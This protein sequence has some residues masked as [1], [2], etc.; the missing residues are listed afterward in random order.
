MA[1]SLLC[2]FQN[3]TEQRF[4][5]DCIESMKAEKFLSAVQ[6]SETNQSTL[7]TVTVELI[8]EP[9][10]L[11]NLLKDVCASRNSVVICNLIVIQPASTN[12]PII[13]DLDVAEFVRS[14][15]SSNGTDSV[16]NLSH[17]ET[18]RSAPQDPDH[19]DLS[20][21][22]CSLR[23]GWLEGHVVICSTDGTVLLDGATRVF[24]LNAMLSCGVSVTSQL[25]VVRC[26]QETPAWIINAIIL[27]LSQ[28]GD[29][30]T[31]SP[32][33]TLN[34]ASYQIDSLRNCQPG[35]QE[36]AIR[37]LRK[38]KVFN[39]LDQFIDLAL[40]VRSRELCSTLARNLVMKR[41][42]VLFYNN[43]NTKT[44]VEYCKR[45]V[46]GSIF[47]KKPRQDLMTE[48]VSNLQSKSVP[49]VLHNLFKGCEHDSILYGIRVE[50]P[51]ALGSV[52][53][54]ILTWNSE[55]MRHESKSH[56][57][58]AVSQYNRF[59]FRDCNQNIVIASKT[60]PSLVPELGC[61][62]GTGAWLCD[63]K[64]RTV[65]VTALSRGSVEQESVTLEVCENPTGNNL[66]TK[67]SG[68]DHDASRIGVKRKTPSF[69]NPQSGRFQKPYLVSVL[70]HEL[71]L[72]LSSLEYNIQ[73]LWHF[74]TTDGSDVKSFELKM[75]ARLK[76][77]C[78]YHADLYGDPRFNDI[79]SRLI[80]DAKSIR[81]GFKPTF[82]QKLLLH[83]HLIRFGWFLTPVLWNCAELLFLLTTV[84]DPRLLFVQIVQKDANLQ[85]EKTQN[86]GMASCSK[87]LSSILFE[88]LQEF[89][90]LSTEHQCGDAVVLDSNGSYLQHFQAVRTTNCFK[91]MVPHKVVTVS[92]A[93]A[94]LSCN[95]H[96]T[97]I[98]QNLYAQNVAYPSNE[99]E[100][101][102]RIIE[103]TEGRWCFKHLLAQGVDCWLMRAQADALV[104]ETPN[105]GH[106]SQWEAWR[107]F[108]GISEHDIVEISITE[109][110]VSNHV[111]A[112]DYGSGGGYVRI[113]KSP[114][115]SVLL[116]QRMHSDGNP[117]YDPLEFKANGT[118]VLTQP[119]IFSNDDLSASE[120]R[121][122]N[123]A[124]RGT[125]HLP[126]PGT[127]YDPFS[128][129]IPDS[130]PSVVEKPCSP[131]S[132]VFN[133]PLGAL[134]CLMFGTR[135]GFSDCNVEIPIGACILFSFLFPHRGALYDYLNR[136]FHLYI[137][138][139]DFSRIPG[140]NV[141]QRFRILA[142]SKQRHYAHG[143]VDF[144]DLSLLHNL[145]TYEIPGSV[146]SPF[147]L[148]R[149][150][151]VFGNNWVY[152]GD[153]N[154]AKEPNGYGTM[155]FCDC[156]D[157]RSGFFQNGHFAK[158]CDEHDDAVAATRLVNILY[159]SLEF[160][161]GG[162]N[163]MLVA[164]SDIDVMKEFDSAVNALMQTPNVLDYVSTAILNIAAA[165][166]TLPSQRLSLFKCNAKRVLT[167]FMQMQRSDELSALNHLAQLD[168][169]EKD[170]DTPKTESSSS[171]FPLA[172]DQQR[173]PGIINYGV[174]TE[175]SVSALAP[176]SD[177]GP[178]GALNNND[179][180]VPA[181][182]SLS[183]IHPT[184]FGLPN[185]GSTCYMNAS[186]Q[187]L[188]H[189]TELSHLFLD[190]GFDGSSL[191][192]NIDDPSVVTENAEVA[193]SFKKFVNYS[194]TDD[195]TSMV[196]D[197]NSLIKKGFAN[198]DKEHVG[199]TADSTECLFYLIERICPSMFRPT[200][201]SV[202]TC[203]NC[204]TRS[205]TL[206]REFVMMPFPAIR[207]SAAATFADCL[208]L[209]L[210]PEVM[211]TP[212]QPYCS[213]CSA[214]HDSQKQLFIKELPDVV[215]IILKRCV[216]GGSAVSTANR[217]NRLMAV[218]VE[219]DFGTHYEHDRPDVFRLYAAVCHIP[220]GVGHYTAYCQPKHGVSW[221]YCDDGSVT[222]CSEEVML[223]NIKKNGYCF[224]F[225]RGTSSDPPAENTAVFDDSAV[226]NSNSNPQTVFLRKALTDVQGIFLVVRNCL[227][228]EDGNSLL[229]QLNS[230]YS[231]V[232]KTVDCD[233]LFK[234]MAEVCTQLLLMADTHF[235]KTNARYAF[236]KGCE[237]LASHC[238]TSDQRYIL[239]K[240]QQQQP[241]PPAPVVSKLPLL[242]IP[243]FHSLQPSSLA[244]VQK[245]AS[246]ARVA[247][248]FPYSFSSFKFDLSF[249]QDVNPQI[250]SFL[251][252]E[253]TRVSDKYAYVQY[254][255]DYYTS[256]KNRHLC[257]INRPAP[258]I[259]K[260]IFVGLDT[261]DWFF[262]SLATLFPDVM[263][264]SP[265]L[266]NWDH[267]FSE[268]RVDC[269]WYDSFLRNVKDRRPQFVMHPVNLPQHLDQ[270][271]H[272][273]EN[274]DSHFVVSCIVFDWSQ[275][276]VSSKISVLDPYS[277]DTFI[278][279]V[280]NLYRKGKYFTS[281]NPVF[282]KA[283]I[284]PIQL[285]PDNI[286]CGVYI[287]ALAL[288]AVFGTLS[289]M[290][291]RLN[292]KPD[293]NDTCDV[294]LLLRTCVAWD[295]TQFPSLL[296][297]C[298]LMS[299]KFSPISRRSEAV[300][301]SAWWIQTPYHNIA[302]SLAI[303]YGNI[304]IPVYCSRKGFLEQDRINVFARN[305]TGKISADGPFFFMNDKLL[306]KVN[307]VGL[308]GH[309]L[310]SDHT[311][312]KRA[313]SAFQEACASPYV[314]NKK[315]WFC[316]SFGL[317]CVGLVC[318]CAFV[319]I[320][321]TIG[322]Q[323]SDDCDVGR[324]FHD[325]S[326]LELQLPLQTPSPSGPLRVVHGDPHRG[327][328]VLVAPEVQLIDFDRTYLIIGDCPPLFFF[329]WYATSI[330]EQR[331]NI[332]HI[333]AL[334]RIIKRSG[335]GA[336]H[337]YFSAFYQ[338]DNFLQ[339]KFNAD[340]F[341]LSPKTP[342]A[343]DAFIHLFQL[344]FE[345]SLEP[346][347]I[348][349]SKIQCNLSNDITIHAFDVPDPGNITVSC[350]DEPSQI[351]LLSSESAT[352]TFFEKYSKVTIS[353]KQ[354]SLAPISP[355]HCSKEEP[356]VSCVG[357][358]HLMELL[359]LEQDRTPQLLILHDKSFI[360]CDI[361]PVCSRDTFVPCKIFF[362]RTATGSIKI[363]SAEFDHP[364]CS[365]LEGNFRQCENV[366]PLNLENNE[367]AERVFNFALSM[368][369]QYSICS[370]DSDSDVD[371]SAEVVDPFTVASLR[372]G[373][374]V[375]Q[376][377][378]AASVNPALPEYRFLFQKMKN[379]GNLNVLESIQKSM[380]RRF[381][382]AGSLQSLKI[383]HVT[384]K[385]KSLNVLREEHFGCEI[386]LVEDDS[387]RCRCINFIQ[388][389]KFLSLDT[390]SAVPRHDEEGISLIQIGTSTNVFLIQVALQS[391]SFF[392]SLAD[393]LRN[394]TL[395]CWG[396]DEK[397][398]QSVVGNCNCTFEDVQLS[399]SSRAQKKGLD[400]CIEDLFKRKYVLNKN[401]RLSG[402]D[403]NPLSKGQLRYAAL[404]VVCCHAL[405]IANKVGPDFVYDS[406]GDHVTFYAHDIVSG[407][408]VKHG[409]SFAPE[410]LGHYNNGSVSRG[411]RFSQSPPLLQGFRAFE[412]ASHGVVSVN[413]V[414]FV[415][416]LNDFQFCCALCSSCWVRKEW[417]FDFIA[418]SGL[419]SC[420][421]GPKEVN[422]L[423]DKVSDN[424]DEQ[425]AYYCLSMLA[426]VLELPPSK[427]NLQCLKQSVCSDIY[428]G[429][430]RETLALLFTNADASEVTVKGNADH[431]TDVQPIIVN[432]CEWFSVSDDFIGHY[433][434]N[435]AIRGFRLQSSLVYPEGFKAASFACDAVQDCITAFT[436]MLLEK[437]ICCSSCTFLLSKH[438][439]RL[440]HFI[441]T[442]LNRS[443][444]S[445]V[446]SFG[447][448]K[449]NNKI[450]SHEVAYNDQNSL[451]VND[452]IFCLT[453]LGA[454]FDL[455]IR[456]HDNLLYSVHQDVHD[457]Y[458]SKT[459]AYLVVPVEKC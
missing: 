331:R 309:R 37:K 7:V 183:S 85:S 177:H 261:V 316:E 26:L 102:P 304:F 186:L 192:P 446:R 22:K 193:K 251:F 143:G 63:S 240:Q 30:R 207:Y 44:F 59:E 28:S 212:N 148:E 217:I 428:Y 204:L 109:D 93:P 396:N 321:R 416:L 387:A 48:F 126:V 119:P 11:L 266:I 427:E 344:I 450:S 222:Q 19:G 311:A 436:Q 405:Y 265:Y 418:G 236:L 415:R 152:S 16:K 342:W 36:T 424:A 339:Q 288:N 328:G 340:L 394:K 423:I 392:A 43:F 255:D 275:S 437:R 310:A 329:T 330:A 131:L 10:W 429:Y 400:K 435:T 281:F 89:D 419:F 157:Q 294:G 64:G 313:A 60:V 280:M 29:R 351:V 98:R 221:M 57:V 271:K 279:P 139:R 347:L 456:V 248:A 350:A 176:A 66:S 270:P 402:W 253:F 146:V 305:K 214:N 388:S 61:M 101:A 94:A 3:S 443:S 165:V 151:I 345:A 434:G 293:L 173:P 272:P 153:I 457:G 135:L 213:N 211:S 235:P 459:L 369:E 274:P 393:S 121:A 52:S 47:T 67:A 356:P 264:L 189:T 332:F 412:D 20:A 286:H 447:M 104:T 299:P 453:M 195:I 21:L 8:E 224:F 421:K 449:K 391:Q 312:A 389:Q 285:G 334:M 413:V 401:W 111:Y 167:E 303:K 362:E 73:T 138:N 300:R 163:A 324:S 216:S 42:S 166:E 317:I 277:Y 137:L 349:D 370:S 417:R 404:D 338:T 69:S 260:N 156:D 458:I 158:C 426:L 68:S 196:R 118:I 352:N 206:E 77:L 62:Q 297:T 433:E 32:S 359:R 46:A 439:Q 407:C 289:S 238:D 72:S 267:Q 65:R 50:Y 168:Q 1:V 145:Q 91:A 223:V 444:G 378:A 258:T 432:A 5:I 220:G 169:K 23:S 114:P 31:W 198:R 174:R 361:R 284:E 128:A 397:E 376:A 175:I 115:D 410:F 346:K 87:F 308:I 15:C 51:H 75:E 353:P 233:K 379:C 140:A 430:I 99:F 354:T 205:S 384:S 190:H 164:G 227:T 287:L 337:D 242:P 414:S 409:F 117:Y 95:G 74:L 247:H 6:V 381:G 322:T 76:S 254:A 422:L 249:I 136:R 441:P 159:L 448:R 440:S 301:A 380:I 120:V 142:C 373:S 229:S 445:T 58:C 185:V 230:I 103:V 132:S 451:E 25:P 326:S 431:S 341:E 14:Y 208:N 382:S 81:K 239:Q 202:V 134:F 268:H 225:R 130:R 365:F 127:P 187:C 9:L 24:L 141:E 372:Q 438:V 80:C 367:D 97:Q 320:V 188:L 256:W 38:E 425:N 209:Y 348:T 226:L 257:L 181:S 386:V 35:V 454:F 325:L 147:R 219:Y 333:R 149:F 241:Q 179:D 302:D 122:S 108:D 252:K 290:G 420:M 452:A 390:E 262:G 78:H 184:F 18:I 144:Y 70:K 162:P 13:F 243:P 335:L 123:Q 269:D 54:L 318:P 364:K 259:K 343:Y 39:G 291:N 295:C 250:A 100:P 358:W 79:G 366:R 355:H 278:D 150:R 133:D 228:L 395:L 55:N 107:G 113:E 86:R 171:G 180:D 360:S 2:W 116:E 245:P 273:T 323:I 283:N 385:S 105:S 17:L 406:N 398:L 12:F 276:Q 377:P 125:S 234:N 129:L 403:N 41:G 124:V 455:R 82:A 182:A 368:E 307:C 56:Y 201:E 40:V 408:K 45:V 296:D 112:F 210:A 411:F 336:T 49:D 363:Y 319:C 88:R 231:S 96:Y 237:L 34:L 357:F 200:I 203:L 71:W 383:S 33:D 84:F 399:Y 106:Q 263:V 292:P 375:A 314:C 327:N 110:P 194:T 90:L 232:E 191:Q 315:G 155:V 244:V 170:D 83:F 199:N 172:G 27:L 154:V 178:Y 442:V 371:R 4:S 374:A 298:L 197:L 215:Y 53:K 161:K 282:E 218:P 246:A 160:L 306:V 92:N